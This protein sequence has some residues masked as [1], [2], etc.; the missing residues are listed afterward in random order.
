[1]RQSF[2]M[3]LL[4]LLIALA[5]AGSFVVVKNVTNEVDPVQLG[6]LRFLVATP[7][8]MLVLFFR[9]KSLVVS[10]SMVPRMIVLGLTGVT[11]LYL[12]QFSGIARTTAATAGVL[13][14]TNVIFIALLSMVFLHERL[15][16][17]KIIGIGLS[18]MG[19]IVIVWSRSSNS[20]FLITPD[21]IFGVFLVIGS[22]FCWAIYSIIGKDVLKSYDSIAV[23]TTAFLWGALLYL[24]IVPDVWGVIPSISVMGW[25]AVLYLAVVCSVLGYLGWYYVLQQM[26]A[27]SAAVYLNFIPLFT[28]LLAMLLGEIPSIIFLG[29]AGLI[30]YGVY[31]AQHEIVDV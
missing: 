22:A 18:F 28:I 3:S 20:A 26:P 29:G 14:N 6:F 13:I 25:L 9:K 16:R 1:M 19:V 31:L 7:L 24:P 17:R 23:T 10:W 27:S 21:F 30:I 5:W 11:F 4:L 12:F 15:S 8:M 2:G